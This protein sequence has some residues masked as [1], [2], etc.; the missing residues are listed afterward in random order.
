MLKCLGTGM[1]DGLSLTDIQILRLESGKPIIE[2]GGEMKKLSDNL[3]I[4]SWHV[5]ITHSANCSH[6]FVLAEGQTYPSWQ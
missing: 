6:A 4:T 2:L 5:S 3:G 1:R